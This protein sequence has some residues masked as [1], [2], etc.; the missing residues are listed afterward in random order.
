MKMQLMNETLRYDVLKNLLKQNYLFRRKFTISKI[1]KN[2]TI[3][4]TRMQDEPLSST[5]T[6]WLGKHHTV[7]TSQF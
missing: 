6:P 5:T 2:F 7:H 4:V 3:C 1:H